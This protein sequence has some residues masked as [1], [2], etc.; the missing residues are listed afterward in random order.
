MC[1][2][3]IS[4]MISYI[5]LHTYPKIWKYIFF[6]ILSKKT[7]AANYEY[8]R[9]ISLMSHIT[10]VLLKMMQERLHN[11][12]NTEV[13]EEQFG[14]RKTTVVPERSYFVQGCCLKNIQKFRKNWVCMSYR[15]QEYFWQSE[16]RKLVTCLQNLG[17]D[18]N[19]VRLISK[20]YWEQTG[21]K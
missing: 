12:I 4:S 21:N 3:L 2:L 7:K 14:F 13:A 1:K 19:N 20:L 17:L 5:I 8:Y 16:T 9:I 15:L 6:I 18:G 10:K 11:K